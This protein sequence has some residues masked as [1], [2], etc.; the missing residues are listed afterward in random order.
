MRSAATYIQGLFSLLRTMIRSRTCSPLLVSLL[1]ASLV[2]SVLPQDGARWTQFRGPG[3]LA[4]AE[5]TSVPVPFDLK[6]HLDW[7]VEVPAGHSSPVV[8]GDRVFLS[9]YEGQRLLMLAYSRST[10]EEL[11]RHTVES[12]GKELAQH[13]SCCPAMPTGCTDGER[14]YF[15]F[16]AYGVSALTMDGELV[17]EKKLPVPKHLFGTANSLI[18]V[19]DA[20]VVVRD[21][22]RERAILGLARKDGAQLWRIPRVTFIVSYSTP[23]LWKNGEREELVVAGTGRVTSFDPVSQKML[24][25]VGDTAIFVCPTP[26]ANQDMLYHAAWTTSNAQ[27]T[28]M[29]DSLF[30]AGHFTAEELADRESFFRKLDSNGDGKVVSSELHECRAKDCFDFVDK[31]KDGVWKIREIGGILKFSKSPGRNIC[32]AVEAGGEGSI[33]RSHV[34]WEYKRGLPYVSSPLL[35]K[36]RLYL[37]KSGGLVTC[38]DSKSGKAYYRQKRLSDFSEAYASPVGVGD[39]VLI[40]AS[41]GTCHFV[42]VAD[43]LQVDAVV[44]FAEKIHATPAVLAD[45]VLI[46]SERHL[47]SIRK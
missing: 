36:G 46:R 41:G 44:D 31:N 37:Y 20:V 3:G 16:G 10:G 11:W 40:C 8:W 2:S 7:K 29:I 1:G 26:T 24:W 28:P 9:A 12:R 39:H 18:L 17:W 43:K 25:E 4:V 21:G 32:V 42:K 6:E 38:L 5:P 23:L 13:T 47:W 22:A 27:G 34:K 35:H 33:T 45:Q 30:G 15:Y 14:V 19:K